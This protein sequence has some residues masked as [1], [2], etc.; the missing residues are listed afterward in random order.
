MHTLDK[1]IFLSAN[2]MLSMANESPQITWNKDTILM[3]SCS[4]YENG[5]WRDW[6][7]C[8][9]RQTDSTVGKLTDFVRKWNEKS[10]F[11]FEF[12]EKKNSF[13]KRLRDEMSIEMRKCFN[14]AP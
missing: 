13:L 5:H 3:Y 1:S 10:N 12:N 2:N 7:R 8:A 6:E 11:K 9:A 4:F 14:N